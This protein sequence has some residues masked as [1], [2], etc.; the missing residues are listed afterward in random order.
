MV[1]PLAEKLAGPTALA[2]SRKRAAPAPKD[3]ERQ[4]KLGKMAIRTRWVDDQIA[5]T[6]GMPVAGGLVYVH[7]MVGRGAS[8]APSL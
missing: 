1:D 2:A 5:A 7:R 3:S 6:L 8:A 4:F